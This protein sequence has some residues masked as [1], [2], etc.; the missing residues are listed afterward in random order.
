MTYRWAIICQGCYLTLD[1][2]CGRAAVGD[3][4]WNLAGRSRG[5]KAAVV[6]EAK[7]LAFL[8]REAA[9]LGVELE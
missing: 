5:D 2:D 9:K 6:N 4:E 3:K 1:N 7:Y 8:R